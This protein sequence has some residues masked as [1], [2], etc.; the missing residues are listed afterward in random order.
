M[1]LLYL[2]TRGSRPVKS[3]F[4]FHYASTLSQSDRISREVYH[5]FTFHYAS[6]LSRLSNRLQPALHDL[7]ST[8]LLLYRDD[9]ERKIY[10]NSYLH[11]TML[12]LY[13]DG[14]E[15]RFIAYNIYIPLCFSFIP[16]LIRD[17]P[18]ALRIYIPLC[19]YFIS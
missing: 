2:I 7:H 5:R 12:L 9:H 6:T 17:A 19:F 4:T 18:F 15:R 3:S 16:R 14:L 8:M 11:S 10:P 1:L 13:H